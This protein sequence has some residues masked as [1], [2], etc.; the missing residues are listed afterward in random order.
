MVG[1][2]EGLLN[3]TNLELMNQTMKQSRRNFDFDLKITLLMV[4]YYEIQR[5]LFIPLIWYKVRQL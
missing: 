3:T 5:D 4:I 1:T 2:N